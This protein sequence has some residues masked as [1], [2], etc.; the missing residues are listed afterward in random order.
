ML[1]DAFSHTKMCF[2]GY[3]CVGGYFLIL[4]ISTN[5]DRHIFVSSRISEKFLKHFFANVY[6]VE[7]KRRLAFG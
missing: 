1:Q 7:E 2:R 6:D 3:M 5:R 4:N